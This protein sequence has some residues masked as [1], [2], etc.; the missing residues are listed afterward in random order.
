MKFS[1]SESIFAFI[2]R[3]R[4]SEWMMWAKYRNT[5]QR[6]ISALMNLISSYRLRNCVSYS[7]FRNEGIT[8]NV[9]SDVNS[10]EY[11]MHCQK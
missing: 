4:L 2:P 8:A 5:A 1:V 11:S 9:D 3:D 10:Q 6:Q 7:S